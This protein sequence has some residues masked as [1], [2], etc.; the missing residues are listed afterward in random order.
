MKKIL[1]ENFIAIFIFLILSIIVVHA[2]LT[3]NSNFN[4]LR[5]RIEK[6][7]SECVEV[8]NDKSNYTDDHVNYCKEMENS[9]GA[10]DIDIYTYLQEVFFLAYIG[11]IRWLS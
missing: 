9:L 3:A 6:N 1:K 11:L 10:N 5:Q 8:L 7:K 2:C 4:N